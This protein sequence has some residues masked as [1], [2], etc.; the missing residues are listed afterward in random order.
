MQEVGISMREPGEKYFSKK[1]RILG[2]QHAKKECSLVTNDLGRQVAC[3][4][5]FYFYMNYLTSISRTHCAE[6]N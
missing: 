2:K 3:L 6:K 1:E 5:W 4:F